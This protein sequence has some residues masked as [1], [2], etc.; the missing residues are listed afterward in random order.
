MEIKRE[1]RIRVFLILRKS[2]S[3][4]LSRNS[5]AEHIYITIRIYIYNRQANYLCRYRFFSLRF[6]LSNIVQP[7]RFIA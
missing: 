4:S 1:K 2:K 6:I 7:I 3:Y 5:I